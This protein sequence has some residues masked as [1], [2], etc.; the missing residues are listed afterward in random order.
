MSNPEITFSEVQGSSSPK[1][2]TSV[3]SMVGRYH[4]HV[5]RRLESLAKAISACENTDPSYLQE[6]SEQLVSISASFEARYTACVE[7]MVLEQL[8]EEERQYEE[9]ERRRFELS[10]ALKR[11][12]A[13]WCAST[14]SATHA[15]KVSNPNLNV[16]LPEIPLPK[17]DGTLESWPA[18]RDSFMSM[19]DGHK[20]LGEVDKLTYL[21]RV[22][23][24]EAAQV[25]ESVEITAANYS[26][27]WELLKNRYENKKVLVRRYLD[28]LFA[29]PSVKRESYE[30]ITILL[31][32]FERTIKMVEKV[33]V[34]TTGWSVLLAHMMCAKLD[35]HT[36]KQWEMFH[37]SS[38]VAEYSELVK[39]LREH[40]SVLQALPRTKGKPVD[41]NT[42]IT[43]GRHK[44]NQAC[45][46]ISAGDSVS[47]KNCVFCNKGIHSA[48]KCNVFRN[49]SVI[50]RYEMVKDK[51]VC[52]N[53]LAPDHQVR[54]CSSSVCRVCRM[55]HHTMLHRSTNEQCPAVSVTTPGAA[56]SGG[57]T[58][59]SSVAYSDRKPEADQPANAVMLTP[60]EVQRLRVPASSILLP[61]VLVTVRSSNGNQTL[62]RAVLDGGAQINLV[63]ERLVQRLQA[64]KRRE[65]LPIGGV[66]KG[67]QTSLFS[68]SLVVNSKRT[69]VDFRLRLHILPE[70]MWNLPPAKV[71]HVEL[72]NDICMADPTWAEVGNIDMLLGR[73]LYND[74]LLDG[75]IR[76]KS[77]REDMLL[78]NTQFGWIVSGRATIEQFEQSRKIVSLACNEPTLDEQI[79]RFWEIEQCQT[80]SIL[81]P[82]ETKC[83]EIFERTTTRGPDG[84]FIVTLPKDTAKMKALG[85]SYNIAKR[86][87]QSLIRRLKANPEL[88]RQYQEFLSEYEQLGH[89]EEITPNVNDESLAYYMPHH[90]IVR[91]DSLTTKLRV[92]FDA[93]CATESGV[94]LNEAL[95]VGPVLQEDLVSI[96]MRFRIPRYAVTAD[97]E[98]MYRQ[99]WI[100]NS[101]RPLQRILWEDEK[102]GIRVFELKTVT[103]GTASA[104]Y[105]ATKSL[106]ALAIEAKLSHPVAS[107]I[108]SSDFYM[109]DMIS[110]ADTIEQGRLLCAEVTDLLQSAGFKLR[111]WASNSRQLLDTLPPE[112]CEMGEELL[113]D[114]N[115]SIKALGLKWTPGQDQLG[116]D[117]PHWTVEERICKRSVVSDAARLFDPLGLIGP[118][119]VVAKC[120]LQELWEKKVD[121]DEPLDTEMSQ[122][123]L[124]LKQEMA[125]VSELTVPRRVVGEKAEIVELHGFSDASQKAYGACIYVR[126]M[127]A[128]GNIKVELLCAKSKVAPIDNSKKQ[129]RVTLPRLELSAALLLCHL[130]QKVKTST[131]SEFK[132]VFWVDSTI[133]LHW[134]NGHPA[135][136]KAFVA[137]RV[138]EI[139]H[140][141][142]KS[143]WYHVPGEE[144]PADIISRGMLP[145]QLKDNAIWWHGPKWLSQPIDWESHTNFPHTNLTPSELEERQVVLTVKTDT[146]NPLFSLRSSYTA[147]IRLV[148]YLLRF[149]A[150]SQKINRTNRRKGVLSVVEMREAT[151]TLT[152]LAQAETF[153]EDIASIKKD[154][155]VKPN[156]KLKS[157]APILIDGILR[158]GGR[159]RNAPVSEARKHPVILDPRHPFTILIM[160][161]YHRQFLHAGPQL[162]ISMIRERF[163][164][165]RARNLARRV[166]HECVKC[167]R[168][169]PK[170]VEQLMGDLPPERVTPTYPFLNTGVDLCGPL[171]Y[172]LAPRKSVPV[173]CY[174]ALFICLVTKAVHVELVSDLSTSSFIATLKRFVAR[175]GKPTKIECDNAKNFRGAANAL[176]ELYELFQTQQAEHAISSHCHAQGIEFKFIP[177]RSPNFGG[178]WEAAIKSLKNHLKST[179]GT[180]V[181]LK[182]DL[183]TL[184]IQIEACLNSRPLTQLSSDPEDME[185][186]TPGHFLVH[187]SLVSIP[188][189]S[190]ES[191]NVNRLD[192]FQKNQEF[193]RRIWKRWKTDYLSGLQQ[194]TKWT[195][196]RDNIKVGTMILLK[197][198]NLP[199]LKWAIGR[200]VQIFQGKDGNVRVVEVRTKDGVYRRAISKICVLPV[201]PEI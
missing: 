70:I 149:K 150:N 42:P 196:R 83:E 133:T 22:V 141:T 193:M 14:L 26:V 24:K 135:R 143:Q 1:E 109:D 112:L 118:V 178:L 190:Y 59:A 157:L 108:L 104:P 162:L 94:S 165:L 147:L 84:R 123:W 101:D 46:T 39:F 95:L 154:G 117:V 166:L 164:P 62:A 36:L 27:A 140:L 201:Q 155:E 113:L 186:L 47:E 200:V 120:F 34:P 51:N 122:R 60:T 18:F 167:F 124:N 171:W 55:K 9:F 68:V 13:E 35:G 192:R 103:Y 41:T 187:R 29:I 76:L 168:T 25:I 136:W 31:D 67:C 148:A 99:I 163:W 116:F 176:K 23:S 54:D 110:G 126:S 56:V 37:R 177:P 137:N 198:D 199:P 106:Q 10:L 125:Y 191:L 30:E 188:E 57:S 185:T 172:R 179:I 3:P 156:S 146:T 48:F 73:E 197:E 86:R 139:Q 89:M 174:V 169:K 127:M 75:M 38:E 11:R 107:Q 93:S 69:N 28:E 184:L 130:W 8:E 121:W 175:R 49:L 53:C 78:Q 33:G 4:A 194:R 82:D 152:R 92:V 144:N 80:S 102:G 44:W 128:D 131:K 91:P 97:I 17:F 145:C 189:P 180:E 182:E 45:A 90:C 15:P 12:Q 132:T 119:I 129:K 98:K 87:L 173:K 161:S 50:Q 61:T 134:I 158:I 21:K 77:E 79:S 138:S 2:A 6:C 151:N 81:S 66:G 7:T 74:I 100:A 170:C 111:K 115:K 153:A 58:R 96:T 52:L 20:T 5:M 142:E 114:P 183:E 85:T 181:L 32:G 65:H 43:S 40:A 105:L 64:P 159:L 71:C 195:S 72:P 88:Q 63:T 160:Q 19:I 16:R